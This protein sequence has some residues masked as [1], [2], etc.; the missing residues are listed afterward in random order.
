MDGKTGGNVNQVQVGIHQ[1]HTAGCVMFENLLV[2]IWRER[3]REG[4]KGGGTKGV[5]RVGDRGRGTCSHQHKNLEK[6]Y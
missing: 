1:L 6:G 3:G 4:G 5:W 2:C